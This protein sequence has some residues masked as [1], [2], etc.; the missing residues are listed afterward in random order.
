MPDYLKQ[1]ESSV[2]AI[3]GA[4][5]LRLMETFIL[6]PNGIIAYAGWKGNM[7]FFI[8]D[9]VVIR[10]KLINNYAFLIFFMQKCNEVW[11]FITPFFDQKY[12]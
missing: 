3:H 9:M 5:V 11:Y 6:L 8:S 2:C 10:C 4:F 12:I 7:Q 1:E